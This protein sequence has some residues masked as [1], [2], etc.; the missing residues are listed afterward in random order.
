MNKI[1][2]RFLLPV[3]AGWF[4][5]APVIATAGAINTIRA[6]STYYPVTAQG[7]MG[8]AI[9]IA[10]LAGRASPWVAGLTIGYQIAKFVI[11]GA[12]SAGNVIPLNVLPSN[13]MQ[14]PP[15]TAS[16]SGWTYDSVTGIW[17]PPLTA[18]GSTS[19]MYCTA[20]P[21][22]DNCAI[23]N[24]FSTA[25]GACQAQNPVYD[26][27]GALIGANTW[28][29]LYQGSYYSVSV[30]L[31][32]TVACPVGYTL[33]GSV[34]NLSNAS[35]VSYPSD[36]APTIKAKP[37]GTGFAPDSRDP[38]ISQLPSITPVSVQGTGVLNGQNIRTTIEPQTGGG[39]KVTTE[40]QITNSDGSLSTFRQTVTV[41]GG[42]R[43]TNTGSGNYPGSLVDQTPT[44]VPI[45]PNTLSLP[46]DYNREATQLL[47]KADLDSIKSSVD[48]VDV[49]SD[50][51]AGSIQAAQD[52]DTAR[53]QYATDIS[54]M[55]TAVD[56]VT[57]VSLFQPFTVSAC[58]PLSY[59]FGSSM[60]A[61]SHTVTLD[62]CPYV[63]TIQRIAAWAMYL[64]TAA[65]LFQMFTRRP[66]GGAD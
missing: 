46:T 1:I 24:V 5:C 49:P 17:S 3:I 54:N 58:S 65:L 59:A 52:A 13:A 6:G 32:P 64:L 31:Q 10:A 12:D 37:D 56:P 44:T 28:Q 62:L 61:G 55:A 40:Q 33:S 23:H 34:C 8:A 50:L 14:L 2:S 38:D 53:R 41:D 29:C 43:V 11:N 60:T 51:S 4:I 22:G 42:G 15:S 39:L 63:P 30:S 35:L 7:A 27:V 18:V 57:P 45:P 66:E 26:S 20:W 19:N 36:N 25:L 21:S 9:D 48:P 16:W 47:I